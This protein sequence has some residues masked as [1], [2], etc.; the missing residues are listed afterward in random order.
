[1]SKPTAYQD[2]DE[3]KHLVS[4]QYVLH[5]GRIVF[6]VTGYNGRK[7]LTIDSVVNYEGYLTNEDAVSSPPSYG[8]VTK[9]AKLT[10]TP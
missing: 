8:G 3:N 2:I 9:T 4:A 7:T 1:M 6:A 5:R 10:V